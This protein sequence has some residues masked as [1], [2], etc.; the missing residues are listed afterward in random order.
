M[1]ADTHMHTRTHTQ[2]RRHACAHAPMCTHHT[3]ARMCICKTGLVRIGLSDCCN[4]KVAVADDSNMWHLKD[5]MSTTTRC[6]QLLKCQFGSLAKSPSRIYLYCFQTTIHFDT[7]PSSVQH[8]SVMVFARI[9]IKHTE[10][11]GWN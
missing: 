11:H 7:I 9:S 1:H 3:S 10:P 5:A 6:H 4:T 2:A 8:I